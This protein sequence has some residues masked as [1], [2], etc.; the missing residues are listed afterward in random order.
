MASDRVIEE[1]KQRLDLETYIGRSVELKRAGRTFKAC[2]PFHAENTPSFVIFPHTQTWHCFGACGVGG[3]LFSYVQRREGLTFAEALR[4]L[5]RE[6]GVTLEEENDAQREAQ[7]ARERLLAVCEAAHQ[8]FQSWLYQLDEAAACRAYMTR[9][10]IS[11]ETAQRF[12]LGYAPAAWDALL[13]ALTARGYTAQ[14][15]ARVG[16]LHEREQGGYYDSLRGRLIFPIR[17]ARGQVVGFGGRAL[18]EEQV[19]KYLNSPQTPLFDKSRTLYGL[20]L[21]KDAIRGQERAIIV[22]G[23]MDVIA[24]HQAG[25]TNVV[26]ALGTALTSEQI[27]LLQRYSPNLT[28]ALDADAAGQKAIERGLEAVLDLQQQVRRAR[29]ERARQGQGR[30]TDIEGD[31]RVLALPAGYD[32]DDLIREEPARWAQLVADALPVVEYLITQHARQANL[33]DPIQKARV[34]AAVLPIIAALDSTLV[35]DHYLQRLAHLLRTDERTLA[36]ELVKVTDRS[37]ATPKAPTLRTLAEPPPEPSFAPP[38]PEG[39]EETE[40]E[41]G[42]DSF[43]LDEVVAEPRP[44]AEP[45]AEPRDLEAYLLYLLLERPAFLQQ[46]LQ[47]GMRGDMWQQTE[48]RQLFEA[49]QAHGLQ[50]ATHL[51]EFIEELEPPIAR[52]LRRIIHFYAGQPPIEPEAWEEEALTRLSDFLI[53]HDEQQARQLHYVLDDLQRTMEA[54]PATMR[55]LLQ[56]K[57]EVEQRILRR[58]RGQQDRLKQ[59]RTV[60]P[61]RS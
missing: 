3:D 57:Y 23:Y 6:A 22:E 43:Y 37:A 16:L 48:H 33:E 25:F 10:G 42:D 34:A 30:A 8:Q 15:M 11:A 35:R 12:A 31:L 41:W 20:D 51:E 27:R 26:A 5:A 46:A 36:Q 58:Q 13:R 44:Q 39:W 29:W 45:G 7:A 54:D 2:C 24:A 1:I 56:Q 19:P 21:A 52:H 32:P 17:D 61:K 47:Q 40:G 38:P 18:Q 55:T 4:L 9:R 53:R 50:S 14:E 59:R 60:E 28:L 49:L